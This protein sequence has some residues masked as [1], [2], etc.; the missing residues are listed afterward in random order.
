MRETEIR[1]TTLEFSK[2]SPYTLSCC[3]IEDLN[4]STEKLQLCWNLRKL[5]MWKA[6]AL[7]HFVAT[8]CLRQCCELKHTTAI[9]Q[10]SGQAMSAMPR[11]W[12]PHIIPSHMTWKCDASC[13]QHHQN[14]V[15]FF[16]FVFARFLTVQ[17]FQILSRGVILHLPLFCLFITLHFSDR[18]KEAKVRKLEE[19]LHRVCIQKREHKWRSWIRTLRVCFCLPAVWDS[20]TYRHTR[21]INAVCES[22]CRLLGGFLILV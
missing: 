10:F 13:Q 9:L 5:C 12:L 17:L 11:L 2:S 16:L 8:V 18:R 4:G 1:T 15:C 3:V 21:S 6:W 20:N 14:C 7:V 19:R 22:S